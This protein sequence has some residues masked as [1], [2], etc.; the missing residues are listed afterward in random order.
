MRSGIRVVA[1]YSRINPAV[2]MIHSLIKQKVKEKFS[3]LF[4]LGVPNALNFLFQFSSNAN[5][6]NLI[7][8]LRIFC[9]SSVS[10]KVLGCNGNNQTQPISRFQFVDFTIIRQK[11]LVAHLV[12]FYHAGNPKEHS[13]I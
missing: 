2:I 9:S 10:L 3:I 8:I 7:K 13:L 4:K 5:F 1:N 12:L 6:Y 11:F